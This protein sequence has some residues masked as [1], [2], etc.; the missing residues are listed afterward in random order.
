MANYYRRFIKGHSNIVSPLTALLRKNAPFN[1]TT[2]CKQAFETM[3]KALLTAPVLSYPDPKRL[4]ILTCDAS[5]KAISYILGQKDDQGREY[6]VVYGGK[7]LSDAEKRYHTSEK[8]CLAIL[9][10]VEVYRPYLDNSL[11]TVVTDHNALTWLKTAKLSK[12]LERWAL[13]LQELNYDIVHR[14]GKSNVVADCLS[15]RSY[16]EAPDI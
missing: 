5:D 8:E 11:F 4:F 15:R 12:R 9:R 14:P 10:D 2:Q 16:T 1:W 7:S 3:K 13:K 6:V